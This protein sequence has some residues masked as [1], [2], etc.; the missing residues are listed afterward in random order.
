ME[1]RFAGVGGVNLLYLLKTLFRKKPLTSHP[2]IHC[3]ILPSHNLKEGDS[4]LLI[5]WDYT[6]SVDRNYPT[7]KEEDRIEWEPG[8]ERQEGNR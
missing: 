6:L 4:E 1:A 3:H 2:E 7:S 8:K 5:H